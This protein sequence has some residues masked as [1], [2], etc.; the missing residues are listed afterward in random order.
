M[1]L[2]PAVC[3]AP[4]PDVRGIVKTVAEGNLLFARTGKFAAGFLLILFIC[5]ESVMGVV[6]ASVGNRVRGCFLNHH[7]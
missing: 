5:S 4:L 6:I 1:L 2:S 7:C 3:P